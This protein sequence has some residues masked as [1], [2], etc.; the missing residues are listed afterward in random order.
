MTI[1]IRK[2]YLGFTK[3]INCNGKGEDVIIIGDMF[4]YLE[5]VHGWKRIEE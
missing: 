4:K 3:C 5:K 2:G 1:D